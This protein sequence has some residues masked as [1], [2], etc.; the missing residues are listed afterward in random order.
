MDGATNRAR[1][2]PDGWHTVTPRIVAHDAK[3]LVEFLHRVFDASGEYQE[4][5]P[6]LAR[7]GDS[8]LMI[9]DAGTRSPAPAFLY[10]YVCDA[11]ATYRRAV[12]A[13]ARV[14][15][16]PGDMPYGDRR[17]M[18]EDKW[19]NTW[20]IATYREVATDSKL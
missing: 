10:I 3:G 11:D 14:L 1:F 18:V 9:S 20:Q 6:S 15:E 8:L 5:V 13:G 4:T 16:E 2:T 7:I 17:C 19:G 12:D